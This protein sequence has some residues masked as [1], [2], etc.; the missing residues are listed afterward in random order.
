MSVLWAIGSGTVAEVR[1]R[2]RDDLAYTT[3][4][5]ILRNLEEKGFVTHEAEGR[6]HR[7]APAVA[8][9]TA[10]RSAIAR[11]VDKLFEGSPEQLLAQ[12]V[13]DRGLSA[14]ELRALQQRLAAA[15]RDRTRRD[16]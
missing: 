10:R 8:R 5:T 1:E 4:L 16:G 14:D 6:A 2:L 9:D 7:Y 11:L 13:E 12:L 15:E 3:V